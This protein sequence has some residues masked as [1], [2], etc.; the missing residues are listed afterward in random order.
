MLKLACVEGWHK[1]NYRSKSRLM[2]QLAKLMKN[3]KGMLLVVRQNESLEL[4]LSYKGRPHYL[5][6]S[7]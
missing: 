2:V 5:A 6:R 4:F 7:S 3:F 1:E